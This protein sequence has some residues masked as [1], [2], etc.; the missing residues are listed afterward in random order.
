MDNLI[1][2]PK[3]TRLWI[4][5]LGTLEADAAWFKRGGSTS[6]RSNPNPASERRSLKMYGI[7]IEHPEEGLILWETGG[8][9]E[10]PEV[11]G[12]PINGKLVPINQMSLSFK[13]SEA[14]S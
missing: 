5:N 3:G 4:L 13:Q 14:S 11:V 10:Y 9:R 7:L 6:T 1:I 12:A 8:G 2:A